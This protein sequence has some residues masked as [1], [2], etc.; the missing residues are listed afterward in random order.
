MAFN[1]DFS[2]SREALGRINQFLQY[3][4]MQRRAMER[5]QKQALLEST[6][7][8]ELS[9]QKYAQDMSVE[10]FRSSNQKDE[11]INKK[12]LEV[13]MLPQ[14]D[15][16]T[17]LLNMAR[18]GKL[19]ADPEN[20]AYGPAIKHAQEIMTGAKE[21]IGEALHRIAI[22]DVTENYL[23]SIVEDFGT[24]VTDLGKELGISHRANLQYEID[25]RRN[26]IAASAESRENANFF[27]KQVTN[28]ID[29]I[30]AAM[31]AVLN[32]GLDMTAERKQ[33]YFDMAGNAGVRVPATLP[34]DVHGIVLEGLGAIMGDLNRNKRM[35]TAE[36][37]KFVNESLN[38]WKLRG[39]IPFDE[40]R[41]RYDPTKKGEAVSPGGAKPS[42]PIGGNVSDPNTGGRATDRGVYNADARRAKLAVVKK[43]IMEQLGVTDTA[44]N[45]DYYLGLAIEYYNNMFLATG[46]EPIPY[47]PGYVPQE[48]GGSGPAKIKK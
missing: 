6:L 1:L 48:E 4:M 20:G 8:S 15:M 14:F 39:T 28:E 3:D 36:E 45:D 46:E 17:S 35:M 7:A 18:A 2:K 42:M 5:Q 25:K 16:A 26:E 13:L 21:R 22:G 19:G 41:P 29:Q 32:G 23:S 40:Q 10:S 27:P 44:G 30:K 43:K 12:T 11:D 24:K 38:A 33:A 34:E 37:S 31:S 9:S 47:P